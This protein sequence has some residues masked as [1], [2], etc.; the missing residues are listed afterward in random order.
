MDALK[1]LYTMASTDVPVEQRQMAKGENHL[2]PHLIHFNR[3]KNVLLD[4]FKI[5][6]SPF[7]RYIFICVM[8]VSYVIWM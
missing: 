1:E 8:V 5:R 6:Q 7:G 3:C 4:E 2:R